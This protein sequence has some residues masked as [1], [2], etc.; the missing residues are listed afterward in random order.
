MLALVYWMDNEL[1]TN[2]PTGLVSSTG[3]SKSYFLLFLDVAIVEKRVLAA[4]DLQ[5]L[6]ELKCKNPSQ[7]SLKQHLKKPNWIL[8]E[9]SPTLRGLGLKGTHIHHVTTISSIF[10]MC[11]SKWYIKRSQLSYQCSSKTIR[12]NQDV[13]TSYIYPK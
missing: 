5:C 2:L 12:H 3:P 7:K 10:T 6:V 13:Y 8:Q 9:S 4:E 11:V 1:Y